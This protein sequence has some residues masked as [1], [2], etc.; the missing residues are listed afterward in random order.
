MRRLFLYATA[1]LAGMSVMAIELAASRLLAPYFS[2]SQIVWT[3][4]IGTIM[5][6]LALGNVWGGRL[7]DKDPNPARLYRRLAVVAVWTAAIPF[8]GKYVIAVVS[9]GLAIFITENFLVWSAFLSCMLI[10]VF[11]LVLLG[12]VT[13]SLVKYAVNTLD[14]TGKTVGGLGALNT[15]GSIIGTFLPTFVTI[16]SVGTALTFIIFASVLM[17]LSLIYF[18]SV[19]QH[20]IRCLVSLLLLSAFSIL[21]FLNRGFAFWTTDL[22]YEGESIYNYLQ[23]GENDWEVFLSTNVLF[24]VQSVK[25][26]SGGL[27]GYCYDYALASLWMAD[28]A[29]K[30]SMDVLILG[31]GAGTFASQAEKYLDNVTLEGVEIDQKIVDIA[32]EYFDLSD[33]VA[34]HVEDGRAFLSSSDKIYDVIFVDAYQDIT[35]PFQMST[36]EFF[37]IARQ[38]LTEDGVL[39]VNL[40]M[41]SDAEGSINQ[42]L[43]HTVA[44]VFDE[45][46]SAEV[47]V[48]GNREV[49]A[50]NNPDMISNLENSLSAEVIPD[51][52]LRNLMGLVYQK[53]EP[54]E[55]GDLI[56]T[57]DKAPVELLGIRV[58][59]EL[60]AQTIL[61]YR[62]YYQE[63]GLRGLYEKLIGQ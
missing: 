25:I 8:V 42:H 56:L 52:A 62:Q 11:P 14:N 44:S 50:S 37:T 12:T 54:V 29:H 1:F 45:V 9:L 59:D 10:F 18:L 2:S 51:Q 15:V 53:L 58:I 26:K 21:S 34:V 31:L 47:S 13:P 3:I 30:E 60:I 46:W 38:H 41:Q 6:A 27:N 35:I 4:I 63:G 16:P 48:G 22:V 28:V 7:A 20:L 55:K 36:V 40:N 24:G 23:V 33:S 19:R 5:I 39:I 32:Y 17:L 43:C 49:Y 57:D 61:E